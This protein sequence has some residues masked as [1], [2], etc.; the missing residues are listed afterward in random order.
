MGVKACERL[1]KRIEEKR[2]LRVKVEVLPAQL[3]IR[4]SVK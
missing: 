3:V 2:P 4:K 1:I